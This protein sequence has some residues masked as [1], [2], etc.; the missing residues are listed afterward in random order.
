MT[1]RRLP[2]GSVPEESQEL[3]KNVTVVT[4]QSEA[5]AHIPTA[6]ECSSTRS[7]ALDV[8]SGW[9]QLQ[10]CCICGNATWLVQ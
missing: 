5:K 9:L 2:P 3:P 6:Q 10:V 8:H 4:G 1:A 7:P